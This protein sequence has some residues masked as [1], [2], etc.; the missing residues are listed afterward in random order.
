MNPENT[1]TK[2]SISAGIGLIL[3]NVKDEPRP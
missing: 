3:P 2:N 1:Q